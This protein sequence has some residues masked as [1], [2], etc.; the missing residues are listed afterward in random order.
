MI[1]TNEGH[2]GMPDMGETSFN[3]LRDDTAILLLMK[4]GGGGKYFI[5]TECAVAVKKT[6]L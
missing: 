2:I 1:F 3:P 5:I 6:L 4:R